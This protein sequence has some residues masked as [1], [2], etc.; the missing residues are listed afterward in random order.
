MIKNDIESLVCDVVVIGAGPGGYT[1][2]FR[3][4]D[5]GKKVIIV[6]KYDTLGGVCLNVGC[7]PSKALLHVAK[8][9]N[10]ANELKDF[11]LKFEHL[12]IDINEIGKYKNGV[13]T[14][15]TSGLSQL[16]KRRK[17]QVIRGVA[18]FTDKNQIEVTDTN[19]KKLI[20]FTNAIIATGSHIFKVPGFPY[21]DTRILDSTT[22]LQLIDIPKE[23]LVVGGG[24]IGLEMAEVYS[25]LGSKIT[26]VELGKSLLPGVDYEAVKV[27]E[28]RVKKKYD[29]I[30]TDTKCTNII[31]KDNGIHVIFSNGKEKRFDKILVATG[32]RPNSDN[33]GLESIGI[34]IDNQG[35]II[36]D[37]KCQTNLDN[38]YAI[39]D[40]AGQPM[41]A[42]K[43]SYEAKIAA[44]NCAS[45][46]SF[47]DARVIP[48][49]AY[50]DPEIAWMGIT[51]EE[52]K[53]KSLDVSIGKFPWAASGRAL[54]NGR[55]DG[56]TKVITNKS[57][58]KIIGATIV[59]T[60][61]SELLGEL[62][63]ALEMDA[64]ALDIAL[65]IHSHPTLSESVALA[66]EIIDGSI[67][68]L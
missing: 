43:A 49:V 34:N 4:S 54:T 9:I 66:C 27:L 11:G 22:A 28:D 64:N 31:A 29:A 51:E 45:L 55:S 52:A 10:E 6:E 8:V 41:L 36:T 60:N 47:K 65:S 44:Q 38:I 53:N 48:G 12:S 63:L 68:D 62:V 7:I 16:A 30:Y 32:R 37:N 14:K 42:H 35:F 61:A 58:H 20:K 67:T 23:M 33:L 59:G 57:N 1:A 25:T 3:A 50:T 26:I 5:L 56:F 21:E 40:V 18:K 24:I 17:V 19:S 13:V 15:L 2:A 46:K 39:G